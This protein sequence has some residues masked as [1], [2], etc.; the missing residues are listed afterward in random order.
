MAEASELLKVPVFADLPQD[1]LAWFIGQSQELPLTADEIY[2][3][4]GDPADAM[5]VVLD[6]QLQL[7]GE[8]AG[9][10][11]T[12][13]LKPGDV[14]GALPF[15]RMKQFPLT[16]RALTSARMLRFPAAQFPALVQKM[17]ELTTRLVGM[18]KQV[19]WPFFS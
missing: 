3:N 8:V 4:P 11:V 1:Q 10:P 14:T 7:R 9:G 15:S 13:V 6:G 17:P 5:Y 18:P 12:I 2:V 19:P 16:G